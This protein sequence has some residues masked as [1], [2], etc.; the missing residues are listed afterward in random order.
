MV[1]P[2]PVGAGEE[3]LVGL[4]E[5][6]VEMVEARVGG[7]ENGSRRVVGLLEAV[8]GAGEP[9]QYARVCLCYRAQDE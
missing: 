8:D 2:S 6:P 3:T 1:D 7:E 4:V 9:A 5:A